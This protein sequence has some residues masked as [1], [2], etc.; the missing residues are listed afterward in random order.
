LHP[1]FFKIYLHQLNP[2]VAIVILNWNGRAFLEQF[3][4]S[5]MA[6]T[7]SNK[8]VVVID[9][10]STDDSVAFL[11]TSYPCIQIV[12]NDANYGF[13]GGYNLGLKQVKADYYILLNSDVEVSP[14][15][16]E[17]AV[18]LL[19]SDKKIAACQPCLNMLVLPVDGLIISVIPLPKEGYLMYVR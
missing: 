1:V 2:S 10:A 3:L 5:V 18:T 11:Q 13:A 16:I 8:T 15:W 14:D 6:T 4:P 17:P 7:Y 12:K 19:E 9:N